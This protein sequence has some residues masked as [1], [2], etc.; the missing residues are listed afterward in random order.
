LTEEE[1]GLET[2][3]IPEGK[4]NPGGAGW[5]EGRRDEDVAKG[6]QGSWLSRGA[7]FDSEPRAFALISFLVSTAGWLRKRWREMNLIRRL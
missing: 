1:D 2:L 6:K 3:F 5:K 4:L 7:S